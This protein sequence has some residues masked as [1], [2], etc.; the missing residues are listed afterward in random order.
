[1]FLVFPLPTLLCIAFP[2]L[3]SSASLPEGVSGKA[4]FTK[5]KPDQTR[6]TT[7]TAADQKKG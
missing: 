3:R 5:N 6:Q 2:P 4:K 7:T 1:M